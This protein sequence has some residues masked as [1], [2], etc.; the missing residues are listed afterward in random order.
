M[1]LLLLSLLLLCGCSSRDEIKDSE[2]NKD[3]ITIIVIYTNGT[4]IV[5]P[6]IDRGFYE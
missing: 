4:Y 6:T 1:K 3:G 2:F 5:L